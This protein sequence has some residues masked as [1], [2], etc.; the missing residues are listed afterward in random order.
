[1]IERPDENGNWPI[2]QSKESEMKVDEKEKT[3]PKSRHQK[4]KSGSWKKNSEEE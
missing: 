1:M 3:E 2:S 4:K